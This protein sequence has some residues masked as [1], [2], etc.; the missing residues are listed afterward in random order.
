MKKTNK[1]IKKRAKQLE[2]PAA[3]TA[4]NAEAAK[5]LA[6]EL[7]EKDDKL[8]QLRSLKTETQ[9]QIDR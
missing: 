1:K 2:K 6:A 8:I 7:K 4:Q 3:K 9:E 5:T